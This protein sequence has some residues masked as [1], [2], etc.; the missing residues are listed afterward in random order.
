MLPFETYWVFIVYGIEIVALVWIASWQTAKLKKEE[1]AKK[2][3][4]R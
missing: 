3:S 4:Q 2:A 1:E